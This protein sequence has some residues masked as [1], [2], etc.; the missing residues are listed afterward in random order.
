MRGLFVVVLVGGT[1]YADPEIVAPSDVPPASEPAMYTHQKPEAASGMFIDF[2]GGVTRFDDGG[3]II[4]SDIVSFSPQATF[5]HNLYFGPEL[6][7]GSIDQSW[8]AAQATMGGSQQQATHVTGS[9]LGVN[10]VLGARA[11]FADFLSAALEVGGGFRRTSI[12]NE[13]MDLVVVDV[14]TSGS[15]R[16]VDDTLGI[17]ELR[18]RIDAWISPH[19]SLGVIASKNLTDASTMSIG[20][21]L[22]VHFERYDHSR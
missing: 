11:R 20:L 15:N 22:G 16:T 5:H 10:L 21:R 7:V 12:R 17:L 18:G 2:G 1:A 3:L 8:N 19:F 14:N 4:H 6:Y 13:D 9:L